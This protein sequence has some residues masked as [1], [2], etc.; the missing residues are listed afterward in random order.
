MLVLLDTDYVGII[1]PKTEA[2]I[3]PEICGVVLSAIQEPFDEEKQNEE[4]YIK[5]ILNADYFTFGSLNPRAIIDK[6]TDWNDSI[7]RRIIRG[8]GDV[9]LEGVKLDS[10]AM[11][12][13]A[14]A[15]REGSDIFYDCAEM[16][17]LYDDKEWYFHTILPDVVVEDAKAHPEKYV[18]VT[19]F[20]K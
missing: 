8:I 2:E 1:P 6:V 15:T 14:N 13:L 18:L 4:A 11:Y 9:I 3:S 19:V 10:L 7:R 5:D 20:V 17:A 16:A 12:E